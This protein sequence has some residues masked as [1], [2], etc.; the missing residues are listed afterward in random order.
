MRVAIVYR[1]LSMAGSL[2][3][4]AVLVA[5]AL[6]ARGLDLHIYCN[7]DSR[8][9]D[10]AGAVF[11]DVRSLVRSRTRLGYPTETASF[12]WRAT[13]ALR[14]DRA[15]Y[16]LVDVRGTAAWE[17]DVV[18][19]HGVAKAQQR[20]WLETNRTEYRAASARSLLSPLLRPHIGVARVVEHL[21]FRPGRFSAAVAVTDAVAD[22]LVRVH[23]VPREKITVIPLPID[24][25]SYN[26]GD[27]AG[28]LRRSLGI[29]PA[30]TLLLFVGNDFER[31]GLSECIRALHDAPDSHL[32]VVGGDVR[33]RYLRLAGELGVQ[34]RVTFVG[35]T[36]E[37]ERY[38][39]AADVFLLPTKE[40]PWG[41]PLIE[42]MAAGVP[43]VTSDAAGA[44]VVV[45]DA[46]AGIVVPA[47]EGAA[48]R[49]AVAQLVADPGE[50]RAL[51]ARGRE[52]ARRFGP[53]AHAEG[54]LAVYERVIA[55]RAA[56]RA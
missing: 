45:R 42:A 5:R 51:G 36:A 49:A 1:N 4:D 9:V 48:F 19:V 7:P 52:K 40:D 8:E 30:Q 50:R 33:D 23:A 46:K 24:L 10:I 17:H 54:L 44:S 3:R 28:T 47:G 26:E 13:R 21:Q 35:S 27:G 6:A 55:E 32:V 39:R 2:E 29:D 37:P 15:L 22:D 43:A 14:R 20:R 11:H 31:K 41:L 53:A 34:E 18:T 25:E 16:D 12:A 38:F 56:R